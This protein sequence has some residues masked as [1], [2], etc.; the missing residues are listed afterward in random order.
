MDLRTRS[1]E[2]HTAVA[3]HKIRSKSDY[4]IDEDDEN[5]ENE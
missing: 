1:S 2:L 5:N 3:L 4:D